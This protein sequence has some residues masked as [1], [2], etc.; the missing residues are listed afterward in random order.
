MYNNFNEIRKKLTNKIPIVKYLTNKLLTNHS[1]QI[2]CIYMFSDNY[3]DQ[4]GKF[5]KNQ[6]SISLKTYR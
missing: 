3:S 1:I 4:F 2:I 6:I 5:K